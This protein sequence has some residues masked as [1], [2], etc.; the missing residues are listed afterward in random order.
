MTTFNLNTTTLTDFTRNAEILWKKGAEGFVPSMRGSGIVKEMSIPDYSGNTREFSTIDLEL[1]ASV[2]GERDEARYAKSQQGYNKI[3]RLTR[4]GK[5]QVISNEWMTQG[6]YSE[7]RNTLTNLLPL[8]MRRMDLDL[9]HRFTFATSTSYTDQ[10]GQTVDL[11]TGDTLALASTSHTLRG[12]S[13]TFRNILANN[14]QVSRGSMEA[15]EK[16]RVENSYN[17]LGQ[18][19]PVSDDII[20]ST[21]DPNTVNTIRE[22][23]K[24]TAS[25]A[26]GAN[27]GTPNV[28]QGKYRHVVLP[29][30]ATDANGSVDS[31][32]AKYWGLVDSRNSSLY[33]GVHQ[34]PYVIPPSVGDGTNVLT[35]DLTFNVRASYMIVVPDARFFSISKG[36]GSA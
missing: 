18:K 6:K 2:K 9:Q 12:S 30:V 1:Y 22:V 15:M 4:F 31:T 34:E 13:T 5:A 27:D 28:Y 11:T 24:A 8:A 23:L 16:M 26:V 29:L 35:D 3:G 20:W 36:D 17:H 19:V 25:V 21:E 32:K 33:L 7:I 10:D 14:P